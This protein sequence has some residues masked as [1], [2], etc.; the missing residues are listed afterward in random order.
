MKLLKVIT[1]TF[2]SIIISISIMSIF[3]YYNIINKDLFNISK[4][5]ILIIIFIINGYKIKKLY[6]KQYYPL[7][8]SIILCLVLLSICFIFSKFN[9]KYLIY[10]L[11]IFISNMFGSFIYKKKKRN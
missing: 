4:I 3:N 6:N 7:L 2:I 1:Y 9:Y 11:I 10:L 8:F 5:L